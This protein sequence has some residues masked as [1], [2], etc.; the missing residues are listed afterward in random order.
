MDGIDEVSLGVRV[1]LNRDSLP[2]NQIFHRTD[3][4]EISTENFSQRKDVHLTAITS[5]IEGKYL[6]NKI[7]SERQEKYRGDDNGVFKTQV[8]DRNT[9]STRGV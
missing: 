9:Q 1:V 8:F 3:V 7:A 4:H 2:K 6:E 5:G